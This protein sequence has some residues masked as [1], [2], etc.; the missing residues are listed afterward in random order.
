LLFSPA[1]ANCSLLVVAWEEMSKEN[2]AYSL[3]SKFQTIMVHSLMI[4]ELAIFPIKVIKNQLYSL[5]GLQVISVILRVFTRGQ[6]SE[7]SFAPLG[8]LEASLST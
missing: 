4:Y 6:L 1:E 7:I 3:S 5:Y 2:K 8:P